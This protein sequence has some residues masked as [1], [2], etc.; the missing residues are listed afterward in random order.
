MVTEAVDRSLSVVDREIEVD[1]EVALGA[2]R[3]SRSAPFARSTITSLVSTGGAV[4]S[5]SSAVA[6]KSASSSG[7]VQAKVIYA[8]L[9]CSTLLIS[10]SGFDGVFERFSSGFAV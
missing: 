10:E 7:S 8:T 9:L 3:N 1:R 6:Q 4:R 5:P 2:A